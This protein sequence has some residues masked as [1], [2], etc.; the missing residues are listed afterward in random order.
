LQ[1][2]A[3]WL[4]PDLF[5]WLDPEATFRELHVRFLPVSYQPGYWVGLDSS[6]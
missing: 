5:A 3:K 6:V 1:Q 4:H 2:V